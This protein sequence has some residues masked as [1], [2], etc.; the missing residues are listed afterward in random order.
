MCAS[1]EK[2]SN[3][4]ARPRQKCKSFRS[5]FF[6]T[7]ANTW[8]RLCGKCARIQTMQVIKI[9]IIKRARKY[10]FSFLKSAKNAFF[11][12]FNLFF[13]H[14]IFDGAWRSPR[15]K[16]AIFGFRLP[17]VYSLRRLQQRCKRRRRRQQHTSESSE[18]RRLVVLVYNQKHLFMLA[19]ISPPLISS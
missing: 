19:C 2:K 9:G 18:Q 1:K 11:L 14:S 12:Q 16:S 6:S 4:K 3:T 15:H 7:F 13:S 5:R 10:S 17:H 8:F